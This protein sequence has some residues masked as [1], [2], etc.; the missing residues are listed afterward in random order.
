MRIF[1]FL[2]IFFRCLNT[3]SC[4][5]Y[6]MPYDFECRAQ[7]HYQ[8]ISTEFKIYSITITDLKGFKIPKAIGKN[9]YYS[10][11]ND[12]LNK[13]ELTLSQ[14]KE[15]QKW[16]NGQDFIGHLNFFYLEINDILE[17]HK[18]LSDNNSLFDFG[19]DAGKLRMN[20][21]E[22][23]PKKSIAC[24]EKILDQNFIETFSNCD[25]K[26]IEG[27]PLL[28]LENIKLCPDLNY[29]S[30]D[31]SFYKGASIKAEL[32]RWIIELNDM[33]FQYKNNR[34]SIGVSPYHFLA[35]MRRWFLALK[36][37]NSKNEQVIDALIDYAVNMLNL[38]AIPLNETSTPFYSSVNE[39]REV[40]LKKINAT[41]V[42][43]ETCLFETKTQ[44]ISSECN[45]LPK[46]KHPL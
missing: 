7:D 10:S 43:F 34:T 1:S 30:A 16:I 13:T 15:W 19:S 35:D 11:K 46:L 2:F 21:R 33:L 36:P 23:N 26:S 39:N 4:S 27:Y 31:L 32:N 12:L 40:S 8:K 3:F 14:N 37:F 18:I 22:T 29:Y 6:L 24:N 44:L 41:L 17:L 45:P 28:N 38:P 9:S 5:D 25:L 20:N 42:F